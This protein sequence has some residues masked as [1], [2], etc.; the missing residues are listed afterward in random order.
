LIDHQQIEKQLIP[1]L[2][3]LGFILLAF[4]VFAFGASFMPEAEEELAM[5]EESL[6]PDFEEPPPLNMYLIAIVFASVG[7]TCITI[8]WKKKNSLPNS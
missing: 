5:N 7:A 2:Q 3:K 6:I 8:A 4:S 1:R